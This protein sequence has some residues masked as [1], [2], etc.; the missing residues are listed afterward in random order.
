[1]HIP[2]TKVDEWRHQG[3]T[4]AQ[5]LSDD[6]LEEVQRGLDLAYPTAEERLDKYL[7]YPELRGNTSVT[8]APFFLEAL[9][10]TAVHEDL[11]S[12]AERALGT[13]DVL[14][15]Q[16]LLWVKYGG[17]QHAQPLHRDYRD[18][19][20]LPPSPVSTQRQLCLILY[21]TDVGPDCGPTYVVS[22]QTASALPMTP[23]L[24]LPEQ[25]AQVAAGEVAVT[26]SAGS[27]L[28]FDTDLL[29]RASDMTDRARMRVSHHL[30]YRP[31][32]C[33]WMGWSAWGH[34]SNNDNMKRWLAQS[35]PRQ[36]TVLGFPAPGDPYWCEETIAITAEHY[37]G[38]DMDPY[39]VAVA[40][41]AAD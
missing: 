28:I 36:R 39:R 40:A 25:A 11:I 12:F 38:I 26:T 4:T 33:H 34:M 7:R 23:S 41:T 32:S 29:H 17:G 15:A 13:T 30:N 2:D 10:R 22:R 14:L 8:Q 1:M 24:L 16:S 37:P 6:E 19:S 9:N 20:L 31:A 27:V 3:Y 35:T 21:Y 18:C 5:L